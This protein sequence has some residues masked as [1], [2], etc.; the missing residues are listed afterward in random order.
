M[1]HSR[2][3]ILGNYF[4]HGK[5]HNC[6]SR[7]VGQSSLIYKVFRHTLVNTPIRRVVKNHQYCIYQASEFTYI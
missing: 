6:P 2:A 1:F 7:D 5:Q 4:D 3:M